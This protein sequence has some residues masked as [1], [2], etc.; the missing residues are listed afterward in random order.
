MTKSIPAIIPPR[1]LVW[2]RESMGLERDAAAQAIGVAESRLTAWETEPQPEQPSIAQ[3][4][5]LADTYRRPI[6][7]FFLPE[8]PSDPA[9]V[10]DFRRLP[11]APEHPT[12]ELL[13]ELRKAATRREIALDLATELGEL[14]PRFTL[15]AKPGQAPERMADAVRPLL[16]V[17]AEQRRLWKTEYAA[18]RAWRRACE[19]L[20]ILVFQISGVST[21]ETRGFSCGYETM[22]VIAIN[23][24]DAPLA[25]IFTI[26]HELGHLLRRSGAACDLRDAGPEE[27]WCNAF[28]GELL[29][30]QTEL[31]AI[32]PAGKSN[33]QDRELK[34]IARH[35]WVSPEVIVRRLVVIGRASPAFYA[36]WRALQVNRAANRAAG[37][38]PVPKRLLSSAGTTFVRL[39]VS[40]FHADRISASTLASYLGVQI[41]H[42]PAIEKLIIAEA[43]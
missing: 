34:R 17:G 1:M 43:N 24:T 36:R 8:P 21:E 29:V 27:V 30:P 18:L 26:A 39:A 15:K 37:P 2:A 10:A 6:A 38:V 3:L 41:K 12:T 19:N 5:K 28:A 16:S 20:G 13:V 42:L 23:S 35:F 14:P 22:P 25:R 40:A 9:L 33:W 32:A 7:A 31:E 11:G 4:R